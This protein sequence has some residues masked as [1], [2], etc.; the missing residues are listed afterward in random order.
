MDEI[1]DA[2]TFDEL[3]E[4]ADELRDLLDQRDEL[5]AEGL[6]DDEDD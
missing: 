4:E 1:E 3:P 6:F 2:W 5:E